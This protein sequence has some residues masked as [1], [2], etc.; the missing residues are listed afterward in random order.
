MARFGESADPNF[1]GEGV[2][3]DLD[4]G[5]SR[6]LPSLLRQEPCRVVCHPRRTCASESV[7][8]A[9]L[10]FRSPVHQEGL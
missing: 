10:V 8:W 6:T 5:L 2:A 4:A 1:I 9:S 3:D 7:W